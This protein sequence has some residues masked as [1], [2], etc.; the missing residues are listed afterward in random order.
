MPPNGGPSL[1]GHVRST[2]RAESRPNLSGTDTV[3]APPDP[4][5]K[6]SRLTPE[7]ACGVPLVQRHRHWAFICALRDAIRAIEGMRHVS[8]LWRRAR[9]S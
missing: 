3:N 8:V 2:A 6:S 4:A 5:P 9:T 7:I 1:S